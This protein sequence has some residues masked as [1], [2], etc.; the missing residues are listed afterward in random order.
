MAYYLKLY[1]ITLFA[2]LAIDLTWLGIVAR[3]FYQKHLGYLMAPQIN[4]SAAFAFYLLFVVGLLVFA[5]EP[6]L[7][8]NSLTS[9]LWRAALFGLVTYATYDLT[10]QALVKDWPIIVTVIDM[11]WG[12]VLSVTVGTI[13]YF[14]GKWL[15]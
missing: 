13:S 3:S 6:G 12:M 9:T 15:S 10:N 1:C 4:W 7:K 2:F 14:A 5:V 11:L 8:D